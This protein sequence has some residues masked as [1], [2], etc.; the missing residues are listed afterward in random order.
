MVMVMMMMMLMMVMML[1]MMMMVMMMLMMMVMMLLMMMMMIVRVE[2][3]PGWGEPPRTKKLLDGRS[4][5]LHVDWQPRRNG[6]TLQT[7]CRS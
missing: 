4:T 1:M 3:C 6:Q 5:R 7:R 2:T